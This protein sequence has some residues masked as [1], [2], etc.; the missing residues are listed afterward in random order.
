MVALHVWQV[1]WTLAYKPL[2]STR[3]I[4]CTRPLFQGRTGCDGRP[5]GWHDIVT[6]QHLDYSVLEIPHTAVLT[7]TTLTT[8]KR[9]H[10]VWVTRQA[11]IWCIQRIDERPGRSW[12]WEIEKLPMNGACNIRGVICKSWPEDNDLLHQIKV[13]VLFA[14]VSK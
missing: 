9:K 3:H 4:K 7:Y 11:E 1:W 10:S 2:R 5:S 6:C 8:K 12:Q 13:F 14:N